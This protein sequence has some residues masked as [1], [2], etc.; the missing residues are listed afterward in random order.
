MA[1]RLALIGALVGLVGLLLAATIPFASAA[2]TKTLRFTSPESQEVFHFS[3][4]GKKGPSLGDGLVGHGPLH[5]TGGA[6]G[7]HFYV[8]C[9]FVRLKPFRAQCLGTIYIA[10]QGQATFQ[11]VFSPRQGNQ[12]PFNLAITGGTSAYQ[13]VGG[14][15]TISTVNKVDHFTVHLIM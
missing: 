10:G 11:G 3:E 1:R 9:T 13:G 14:Q 6:V 15:V 5:R 7:G 2:R 8:T 4:T 12:P